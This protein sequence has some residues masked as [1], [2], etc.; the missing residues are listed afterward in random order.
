ML[1]D[2]PSA[3]IYFHVISIRF[4]TFQSA[5]KSPIVLA[6]MPFVFPCVLEQYKYYAHCFLY[7]LFCQHMRKDI[8]VI[9]L[10]PSELFSSSWFLRP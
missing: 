8:K 4:A 10:F 9:Q 6:V 2:S 3:H 7:P 5:M 1:N